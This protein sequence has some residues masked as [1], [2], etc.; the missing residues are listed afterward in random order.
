MRA[1]GIAIATLLVALIGCSDPGR[2]SDTAADTDTVTAA[3]SAP[4][5]VAGSAATPDTDTASGSKADLQA[6]AR[7]EE[8]E[9]EFPLHGL[10]TGV[11]L[12][13]RQRPDPDAPVLGWLR[14]GA[15]VR[16]KPEPVKTRTCA[17][18]WHAVHPLG[19]ACAG[20]GIET[21]G[22]PPESPLAV[23][24]P[25]RDAALPYRYYF[26]KETRVPEW[27]RLPSR[28]EQ[29][30]AQE[31]IQRYLE[32]AEKSEERAG[33]FLRGEIEDAVQG[34]K[35]VRRYLDRGFFVAGV[36]IE[37]RQSRK[38]VRTVRGSYVQLAQL[39]ERHGSEFRGVEL[40]EERQLPVAWTVR[41][42][43]P[44]QVRTRDDGSVAMIA[45]PDEEP[46]E[47]Q[48][49]LPWKGRTRVG[50]RLLHEL[51][52]GR[53]LKHWFVAVAEKVP[54]PKGVG[55]DEP[56]VHVDLEQQTLVLYSGDDPVYA[57]LV[58]SGLDG[59]DTPRGLFDI[60]LKYVAN[61]M[62]DLGPDAGDDRYSIDDVPWTQYFDGSIALHGAFWHER[63][64]LKRSHGCVN[65]APHDAH[66]VFEHTWPALPDGWHG[67]APEQAGTPASK[68]LVTG[69]DPAA[70]P[71]EG[72]E[73]ADDDEKG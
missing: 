53:Y 68:V 46:I 55:A 31:F 65:L 44:F 2:G 17:T 14:M 35:V 54:R 63:F 34:T 42:A 26:V 52:D 64:G 28:D 7:A 71:D 50:T 3:A 5:T 18:G 61:G 39:Q 58:S 66:R 29:R 70:Q 41:T 49:I 38:F 12:S 10:V 4:D 9:R 20:V 6:Q 37:E 23:V 1:P 57:T 8:L 60:R 21:G 43:R 45:D 13:V 33:K 11:Q 69:P 51:E 67:I 56:W 30:V 19:W 47:R 27:H 22:T 24:P 73:Q 32:L 36:A 62:A 59:H 16:L 72:G 48:T 15:R 25:A 40:G